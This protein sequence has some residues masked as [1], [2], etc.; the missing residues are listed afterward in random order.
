M[1]TI[2]TNDIPTWYDRTGEGVT[3][4]FVHG[5]WTDHR[6]WE[7]QVDELADDFEVITYDVRGH[8]RTG[9]SAEARYT[10]ELFAT[11]LRALIDS[12]DIDRPVLC[13]LSLGGMIAQTFASRYSDELRGL[14]LAD[15]AVSS[16]LTLTDTLQTLLFPK[17]AMAAT[18]RMLG[19][20]KWVDIAF[21]LAELTRGENWFGRDDRVRSY[22]RGTM[23]EFSAEEYNKIFGAVYG[24]R[25]VDLPAIKTPTLVLNGEFESKSVFRHTEALERLVP[26]VETR[27]IPDAGHTSNMENPEAFNAA[28]LEFI[29]TLS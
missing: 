27:V 18:V 7:P 2:Q 26:N 10:V 19:P 29:G 3:I 5:A 28:V 14:I 6:M 25:M 4:V 21:Q 24:F 16:R 15:T 9:G 23:S 12:L 13:G 20:K 17:W 22:V 8:G 1:P 11:D